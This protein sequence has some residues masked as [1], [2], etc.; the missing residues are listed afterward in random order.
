MVMGWCSMVSTREVMAVI[1]YPSK[2]GYA[3]EIWFRVKEGRRS[4]I[5]VQRIIEPYE[6]PLETLD[7]KTIRRVKEKALKNLNK[8]LREV[9]RKRLST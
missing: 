2:H 5:R 8:R 7:P 4:R 9:M 1:R 3:T 6:K